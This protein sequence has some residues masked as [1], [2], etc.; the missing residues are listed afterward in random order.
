MPGQNYPI[1]KLFGV[2]FISFVILLLWG[3][4]ISLYLIFGRRKPPSGKYRIYRYVISFV[5]CYALLGLIF[6]LPPPPD[7]SAQHSQ[8]ISGLIIPVVGISANNIFLLIILDLVVLRDKKARMEIEIAN[9]KLNNVIA[10]R[11]QLQ[12]QI[13]PHFLFNS[14]NALKTLMKT[15]PDEAEAYILNLSAFLRTSIRYS[16]EDKAKVKEELLH[17]KEYLEMQ[18]IRF[19]GSLNYR[20]QI[21]EDIRN[22]FYLPVFS[23]QILAENAIKHN[24]FTREKPL[25]IEIYYLA[26]NK[27]VVSNNLN[28]KYV[29]DSN[30]LGLENL[31]KRIELMTNSSASLEIQKNQEK[32]CAIIPLIEQ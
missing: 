32:F 3:I 12:S 14:L 13:Q 20:I 31:S 2:V 10:Q 23:L 6:L 16:G 29:R 5:C 28:V 22:H 17:C 21:D 15:D 7:V 19:G 26:E 9:L 8:G 30:G 27:I 1:R 24:A 25:M 4:N 11:E 18:K